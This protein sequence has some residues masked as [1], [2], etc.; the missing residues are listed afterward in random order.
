MG[1]TFTAEE[2]VDCGFISRTL[3]VDGFQ[4]KVLSLAE[5]AA[6]FSAEAV[7]VSKK[8]IRDVDRKELLKVNEIE[9][10]RLTERMQSKD[11]QEAIMNFVENTKRKKAAKLAKQKTSRL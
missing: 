5:E 9:M 3:A 7:A 10:E 1:R 11:S 8:L 4:E 6:K 2:L